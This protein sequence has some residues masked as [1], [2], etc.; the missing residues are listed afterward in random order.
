MSAASTHAPDIVYVI[1]VARTPTPQ[2]RNGEMN[3]LQLEIEF[4]KT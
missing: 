4:R 3:W 1:Y 2:V